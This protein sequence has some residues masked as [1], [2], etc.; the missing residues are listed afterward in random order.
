VEFLVDGTQVPG[1]DILEFERDSQGW[2][3]HFWATRVSEWERGSR[4]HLAAQ[5]VI[6]E[7]LN[8][9]YKTYPPGDYS[10]TLQVQVAEK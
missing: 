6:R 7:A 9:G 1:A 8:D 4:I 5:Y 10:Y 2:R 3:C